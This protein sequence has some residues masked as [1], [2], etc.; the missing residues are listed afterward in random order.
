MEEKK[1]A[2]LVIKPKFNLLMEL[3]NR[4]IGTII[5]LLL[6][7][8]PAVKLN[9]IRPYAICLIIYTVYVVISTLIRMMRYQYSKYEFFP[10]RLVITDSFYKKIPDVV[11]YKDIKDVLMYQDYVQ[12]FFGYGSIII[13]I[14]TN[15]ILK[16]EIILPSIENVQNVAVDLNKVIYKS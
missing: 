4:N 9:V 8:Y 1:G 12:K 6:L 16:K 11:E 15:N 5:I 3:I 14:D 2:D 10:D 13:K 7:I